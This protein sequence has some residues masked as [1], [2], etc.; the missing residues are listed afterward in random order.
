MTGRW[1]EGAVCRNL[2]P[3][4]FFPDRSPAGRATEGR[5]VALCKTCP[6]RSSCLA[7]ALHSRQSVGV[8]GGM[9]FGRLEVAAA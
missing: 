6:V 3:E 7:F 2:P 4:W 1:E 8:W 5:A 9:N